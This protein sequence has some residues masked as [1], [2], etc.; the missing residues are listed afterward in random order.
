MQCFWVSSK[1]MKNPVAFDCLQNATLFT[2]TASWWLSLSLHYACHSSWLLFQ[3]WKA[4]V[5]FF[6]YF[7]TYSLFFNMYIFNFG[8]S[9]LFIIFPDW[10]GV[11]SRCEMEIVMKIAVIVLSLA[12]IRRSFQERKERGLPSNYRYRHVRRF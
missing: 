11:S 12:L 4:G 8:H 1:P 10:T 6:M 7:L 2:C 3:C 5:L 9:C